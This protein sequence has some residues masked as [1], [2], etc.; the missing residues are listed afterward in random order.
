MSNNTKEKAM[1]LTHKARS[2]RLDVEALTIGQFVLMQI[3]DDNALARELNA[4]EDTLERRG[5][6]VAT[7]VLNAAPIPLKEAFKE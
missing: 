1:L 4:L 7:A 3:R 6:E 5:A 2:L